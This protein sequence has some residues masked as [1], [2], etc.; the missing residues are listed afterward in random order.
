M[1][2]RGTVQFQLSHPAV[3][4]GRADGAVPSPA[5]AMGRRPKVPAAL[6]S[7][8]SEYA[9]LLR[10]LRTSDTLDLAS[11]LAATAS[12]PATA[13]ASVHDGVRISDDEGESER[14]ATE[15]VADLRELDERS[16]DD[17]DVSARRPKRKAKHKAKAKAKAPKASRDNWTRWPLL[18]GDVYVPEWSLEDE[19]RLLATQALKAQL[20]EDEEPS[21]P[22]NEP[23]DPAIDTSTTDAPPA[24]DIG[25][26]A[27][28]ESGTANPAAEESL[29]DD[30]DDDE[31]VEEL[32]PPHVLSSLTASS[33]R[34]LSQVLALLAAYVP[35]SEKSMQNRVHPITWE[36]I[37]DIVAV[38]GL[39]D[40]K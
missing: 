21:L 35:P 26:V 29:V 30:S 24:G 2:L 22:T 18:A 27:A 14:P 13:P 33:G 34:F 16:I 17:D 9:S 40:E 38:N 1:R 25:P 4:G 31:A 7:E 19:V 39:V 36:S 32:L 23:A 8:L 10:A 28:S 11:Q 20:R 5:R 37:V 12:A 15:S 6:H 3:L